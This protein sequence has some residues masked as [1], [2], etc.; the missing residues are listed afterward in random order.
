MPVLCRKSLIANSFSPSH[1]TSCKDSAP[2]KSFF[3]AF[4][5]FIL[6]KLVA[7]EE[8]RYGAMGGKANFAT[9]GTNL[10]GLA[11]VKGLSSACPCALLCG[12]S[13]RRICNVYYL[14]DW[15]EY[16]VASAYTR[17]LKRQCMVTINAIFADCMFHTFEGRFPLY[18]P[19]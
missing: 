17:F 4:Y 7:K 18:S 8:N 16:C 9:G 11:A 10:V 1:I 14:K 5:S 12:I 15:L 3:A 2:G 6:L 13:Y 19:I